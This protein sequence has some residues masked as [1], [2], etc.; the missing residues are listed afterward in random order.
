M[1]CLLL[2]LLGLMIPMCSPTDN[3]PDLNYWPIMQG[4]VE[5]D[6][7]YFL[8]STPDARTL[9]QEEVDLFVG[10]VVH[11]NSYPYLEEGENKDNM[12]EVRK[13]R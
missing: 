9:N 6:P 10:G 7:S 1:P 4:V 5:N 3:K 13:L 12:D 2:F 11:S 8:F